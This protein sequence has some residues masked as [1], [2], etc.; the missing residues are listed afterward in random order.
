MSHRGSRRVLSGI[1]LKIEDQLAGLD[2]LVNRAVVHC[3]PPRQFHLRNELLQIVSQQHR[4]LSAVHPRTA[5]CSVGSANRAARCTISDKT[6]VRHFGSAFF[7]DSW[8]APTME[9]VLAQPKP[10]TEDCSLPGGC[11]DRPF[12][13]KDKPV[14]SRQ[15]HTVF[16]QY[17]WSYNPARPSTPLY[18]F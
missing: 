15:L 14:P 18:G 1:G 6:R 10:V 5:S 13:G 2:S 9:V 17:N 4:R 7:G 11:D 16:R 8:S 12:F 3:E